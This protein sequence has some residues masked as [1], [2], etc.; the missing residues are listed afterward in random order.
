[1]KKTLIIVDVQ[2][3]FLAGGALAVDEAADSLYVQKIEEIR[4]LFD[5]VILT[6]DAH[7]ENHISFGQFPV[8]CVRG[9]KGAELAV[10]A[11]DK[12]LLKGQQEDYEEFS[13]LIDGRDVEL[14][15]GDEVYVLGLA[16]DYCVKDTLLDL[17]KYAPEKK[18]F[19]IVDLIYSV[20]GSKYGP[21]DHFGGKVNFITSDKL[22]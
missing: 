22:K 4:G 10:K 19:A 2:N 3:D 9:T 18:L 12:L 21:L 15:E 17:I 8:H 14:I 13:P 6:A 5:Q 7:P 16:G 20:D 11:G 1:M